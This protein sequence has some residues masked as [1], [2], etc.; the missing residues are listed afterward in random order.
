M[1]IDTVAGTE[2]VMIEASPE[3]ADML[4]IALGTYA[5]EIRH[6]YEIGSGKH[7]WGDDKR[8]QSEIADEFVAM[9]R[10]I[11]EHRRNVQ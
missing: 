5:D 4:A 7:E 9:E 10:L 8:S 11:V 2:T 1:K 3:E 6:A